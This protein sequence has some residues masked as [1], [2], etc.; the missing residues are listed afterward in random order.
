[1]KVK[2]VV[3]LRNIS[4]SYHRYDGKEALP[5]FSDL[6]FSLGSL[7]NALI[8]SPPDSGKSTLSR[9]LC[10]LATRHNEGVVTGEMSIFNTNLLTTMPW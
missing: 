3:N 10:S 7:E 5:L 1:M 9:I 2:Q 8:V 6:N 4:F